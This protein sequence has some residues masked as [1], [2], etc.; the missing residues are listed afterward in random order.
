ML[1]DKAKKRKN[2]KGL[3][4]LFSKADILTFHME[5]RESTDVLIVAASPLQDLIDDGFTP[6]VLAHHPRDWL[7][8]YWQ[9]PVTR[10]KWLFPN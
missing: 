6:A 10:E 8:T 2:K 4:D 3:V 9:P 7:A 5:S 1:F